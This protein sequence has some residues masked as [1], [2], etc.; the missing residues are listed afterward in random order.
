M[1]GDHPCA[2]YE[3]VTVGYCSRTDRPDQAAA[4]IVRAVCWCNGTVYDLSGRVKISPEEMAAAA[5]GPGPGRP[6]GGFTPGSTN[7]RAAPPTTED[8]AAA[9][10][11]KVGY[12]A[13]ESAADRAAMAEQLMRERH[14]EAREQ[15]RQQGGFFR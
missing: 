8:V 9:Y 4:P 12:R 5:A 11:D 1:A 2:P 13:R 10:Q 14:A 7:H 3:T 15:R 6:P